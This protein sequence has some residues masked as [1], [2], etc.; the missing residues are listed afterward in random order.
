MVARDEWDVSKMRDR[1]RARGLLAALP[2]IDLIAAVQR[3]A[4]QTARA[5]RGTCTSQPGIDMRGC[6]RAIAIVPLDQTFDALMN[7][8]SGYRAQYYLSREEGVLFN[9]ALLDALL[10]PI[11]M[12]IKLQN[13]REDWASIKFSLEGPWSKVWVHGDSAPFC[14]APED[15]FLPR[16][17]ARF[18]NQSVWIRAPLPAASAIEIKGTWVSDLDGHYKLD[19]VKLDRDKDI[20]ERGFA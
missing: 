4:M 10:E 8:R 5:S 7:G 18:A 11:E 20:C 17:W 13:S 6:K 3:D 9:R 19:P 14:D 2:P 15:D 1:K 16:R 12:I